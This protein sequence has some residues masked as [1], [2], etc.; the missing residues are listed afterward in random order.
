M[1]TVVDKH[2]VRV[3][4]KPDSR[5]VWVVSG[6]TI[7]EALFAAAIPVSMPCGGHGRC[8]SCLVFARGGLSSPSPDELRLLPAHKAGARLACVARLEGDAEITIPRSSRVTID[9][10][11]T[12]GRRR[13][14]YRLNPGVAKVF[15][16]GRKSSA[17][18][19]L[20][21]KHGLGPEDI[22]LAGT[23]PDLMDAGL[24]ADPQWC[25]GLHSRATLVVMDRQIVGFEAGD[26]TREAYGIALDVGTNTVV[27]CLVDLRTGAVLGVASTINPQVVHG[28]DVISR[29][30]FAKNPGG[31]ELLR[32]EIVNLI[33]GL[34]DEI[35]RSLK[36]DRQRIYLVSAV[37][38]T[39]M[40]HILMG[41][42]PVDLGRA[43]Y[44]ARLVTSVET[45]ASRIGIGANRDCKL[46]L[47]P[48]VGGF[49]GGDLVALIVSQGL[50]RRK[51]PV[52]AVDL[53]TNGE[54]VLAGGGKLV[55][56][57]TAAGPAFEGERIS[58][59]VRAIKGAIEDVRI[60][61]KGIQ[62]KTIGGKKPVGLCGSGLVALVAELVRT[63]VIDPTGRM[64]TAREISK[65]ALARR[66]S[67]GELGR[68]FLI[69][70]RP[71]ISLR[72]GDVRE[73]QLGKAALCAGMKV[74]CGAAG[75]DPADI[76]EVMVAGSFGSAL[77][78]SSIR[79]IGLVPA[80]MS[81]KI[82]V[83]GNSAIEGAKLFLV[84]DKAREDAKRIAA[85]T[86]HV[87]LFTR[88]EFKDEFYAS[89]GFPQAGC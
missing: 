50:E 44:R 39:A 29:I 12:R 9:K 26:T 46:F 21:R 69:W 77:K 83:I 5:E 14:V 75:V 31:L 76:S 28:D 37:G 3:R 42:S 85:E 32:L 78:P 82:R 7:R 2:S 55:A 48:V 51:R 56:C 35:V 22:A 15:L 30:R 34:V 19:A 24:R 16:G 41:I 66:V 86:E 73:V 20:R 81:P 23:N 45:L 70:P 43:P 60:A 68:E 33:N 59:G 71:Q 63:G 89:M 25:L 84:S 18:G 57:S 17:L 74:L 38:N 4:F 8:G 49:V 36:L 65:A 47:P 67:D 79:G 72:Q 62:V 27:A 88:T 80:E 53:G 61:G 6:S 54:L 10:M 40:Q 64:K 11:A 87:E 1:G 58:A 13:G 52:L